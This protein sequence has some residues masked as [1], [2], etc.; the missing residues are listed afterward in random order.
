MPT[1][2]RPADAEPRNRKEK[3]ASTGKGAEWEREGERERER[4]MELAAGAE[5]GGRS[6]ATSVQHLMQHVPAMASTSSTLSGSH[7][8]LSS[9][10]PTGLEQC[11][12]DKRRLRFPRCLVCMHS[13]GLRIGRR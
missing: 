3:V 4:D 5:A 9:Q 11:D 10:L 12:V 7:G 13:H 2:G 1:R 6:G 8:F